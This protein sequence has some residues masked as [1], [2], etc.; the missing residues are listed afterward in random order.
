M[1]DSM[2]DKALTVVSFHGPTDPKILSF[3]DIQRLLAYALPSVATHRGRIVK[4]LELD[5]YAVWWSACFRNA[6]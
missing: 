6:A 4:D 5:Q 2:A 1:S 3:E